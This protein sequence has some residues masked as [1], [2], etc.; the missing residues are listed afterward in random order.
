[1]VRVWYPACLLENVVNQSFCGSADMGRRR[2]YFEN[3][4]GE[5]YFEG[6]GSLVE[7]LNAIL[8]DSYLNA[9][10]ASRQDISS[11]PVVIFS[12]G[13][14]QYV[15]QNTALMQELASQGFAVFALASPGFAAGVLYAN[16]DVASYDSVFLNDTNGEVFLML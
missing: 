11:L 1:M 8:T 4:E 2:F 13:L 5:I 15:S 12:H 10:V 7:G 16:G 3:G 9:P 6:E 14:G